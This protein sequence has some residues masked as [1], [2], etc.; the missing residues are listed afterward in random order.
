MVLKH[1]QSLPDFTNHTRLNE[2]LEVVNDH[3]E[4]NGSRDQMIETYYQVEASRAPEVV[5]VV[6][7]PEPEVVVEVEPVIEDVLVE[8]VEESGDTVSSESESE[9][10]SLAPEPME[11]ADPVVGDEVVGDEVTGDETESSEESEPAPKKRS[12]K[13]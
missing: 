13:S 10:S 4:L 3:S 5:E 8:V 1:K 12:R 7:E 2:R 9:V 6:V 11:E